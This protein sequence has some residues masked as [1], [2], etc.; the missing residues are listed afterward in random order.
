MSPVDTPQLFDF[1]DV[2]KE[3]VGRS[4]FVPANQRR[5]AA[6]ISISLWIDL[7]LRGLCEQF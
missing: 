7:K 4:Q 2:W 3:N 6:V 5:T 1:V